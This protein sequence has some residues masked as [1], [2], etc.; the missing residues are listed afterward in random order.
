M[1]YFVI[2]C[3]VFV[4]V[5]CSNQE[6]KIE[7]NNKI[8]SIVL[9]KFLNAIP[10]YA[11]FVYTADDSILFGF[12]KGTVNYDT[13]WTLLISK[14]NGS[15]H[16]RYNQLLPYTVTGFDD[17][18]DESSKLLYYEGFSFEVEKQGWDSII[19]VLGF[20]KYIV[21]DSIPYE[22]CPHCP[23][24]TAYYGT[25]LIVNSKLDNEYLSRLDSLLRISII[26]KLFEKRNKPK[27]QFRKEN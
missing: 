18:L 21:K 1:K 24:Y 4:I 17:Y 23:R 9:K 13:S 26:N 3:L 25:N 7:R 19:G 27:A 5:S 10:A 16:C 15:I 20:D 2:A 8:E 14:S 11:S 22:G 12:S 6:K